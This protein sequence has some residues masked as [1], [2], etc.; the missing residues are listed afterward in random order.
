M[1]EH[2]RFPDSVDDHEKKN[3]CLMKAHRGREAVIHQTFAGS[4]ED[5]FHYRN[6]VNLIEENFLEHD[7]SE[8]DDCFYLRMAKVVKRDHDI[9]TGPQFRNLLLWMLLLSSSF[10]IEKACTSFFS[11]SESVGEEWVAA[12]LFKKIDSTNS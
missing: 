11:L 7:F 4:I 5:L 8:D 10:D 6:F 1:K 2:V 3:E 9:V 12:N